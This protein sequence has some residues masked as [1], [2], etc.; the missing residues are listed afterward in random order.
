[1]A[2]AGLRGERREHLHPSPGTS[3]GEPRRRAAVST[4]RTSPGPA[5]GDQ[6]RRDEVQAAAHHGRGP[7]HRCVHPRQ[8]DQRRI[9]RRLFHKNIQRRSRQPS[10]LQ[11]F[12]QCRLI[13]QFTA[14]RVHDARRLLHFLN[15]LG[16]DHFFASRDLTRCAWK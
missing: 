1:M 14:R 4:P 11:R 9:L 2:D 6:H 15:G 13:D 12:R 10:T 7:A 16:I 3:G 8:S 5:D